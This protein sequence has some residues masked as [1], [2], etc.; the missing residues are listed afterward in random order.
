MT[1]K[2]QKLRHGARTPDQEYERDLAMREAVKAAERQVRYSMRSDARAAVRKTLRVRWAKED[3]EFAKPLKPNLTR[4]T[5]ADFQEIKNETLDAKRAAYVA[6]V[7]KLNKGARHNESKRL[8]QAFEKVEQEVKQ[9][10][11]DERARNRAPYEWE[12]PRKPRR[13]L[14]VIAKEMFQ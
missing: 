2:P 13:Q 11:I 1:A 14:S 7:R 12:K 3:A 5:P 6:E 4:M 8:K 9:R 10:D